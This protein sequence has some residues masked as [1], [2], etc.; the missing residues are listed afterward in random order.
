MVE[1]TWL[2]DVKMNI[3][4]T[5]PSNTMVVKSTPHSIVGELQKQKMEL[6]KQIEKVKEGTGDNKTKAERIKVINDQ[7]EELNKQMQQVQIEEQQKELEKSQQKNAEKAEQEKYD[8]ADAT[9][10]EGVV[11]SASLNFLLSAKNGHS[12]LKEM[13]RVRTKLIGEMHVAES[14]IKNSKGGDVRYSM[15]VVSKN[16]E[17]ISQIKDK[18]AKDVGGIQKDIDKSVKV[19]INEA[20]KERA[21]KQ[22]EVEGKGQEHDGKKVNNGDDHQ[23][24]QVVTPVDID[25]VIAIQEDEIDKTVEKSVKNVRSGKNTKPIDVLA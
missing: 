12:E 13:S 2:G 1:F 5:A 16:E 6:G 15:G 7:I 11:L 19:G 3:S 17:K 24:R 9:E 22:D 8:K 14:K 25:N 23:E 10:K 18:M 4:K 21:K 20:E